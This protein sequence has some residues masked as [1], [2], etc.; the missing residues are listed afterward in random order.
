MM[1]NATI[2]LTQ[3]DPPP[4][5]S[6]RIRRPATSALMSC[7]IDAGLHLV[8]SAYRRACHQLVTWPAGDF[9]LDT[10]ATGKA[11]TDWP[12]R[13]LWRASALAEYAVVAF[14]YQSTEADGVVAAGLYTTAGV[15][16]DAGYSWRVVDGTLA[17]GDGSEGEA[18][19]VGFP[20]F[21]ATSGAQPHTSTGLGV[22]PRPLIIPV[23]SRGS[24]VE[25]RL[26]PTNVRILSVSVWEMYRQQIQE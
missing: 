12:V 14:T 17:S 10:D 15:S 25:A 23:G 11:Y 5:E 16:L 18:D 2:P 22:S 3:P 21:L 4:L 24:M 20:I 26:T 9:E 7:L 1:G 19:L 8:G 6:C 13:V